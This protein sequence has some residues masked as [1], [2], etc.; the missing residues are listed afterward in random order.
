MITERKENILKGILIEYINSAKPIS[1]K[2]IKKKYNLDFCSA[3]IRNEMQE[4]SE[5]GFL[6][7]PHISA[8]RIP[9]DKAYRFFVDKILEEDRSVRVSRYLDKILQQEKDVFNLTTR[10]SKFLAQRSLSLAAIHLLDDDFFYKEGWGEILEK[11][12]SKED[13]FTSEFVNLIRILEKNIKKVKT[14]RKIKIY[15]GEENPFTKAKN[16]SI[17]I[18]RCSFPDNRQGVISLLGPKRMKYQNN[19]SLIN[20]ILKTLEKK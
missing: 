19:I 18:T 4:L 15:I 14:K 5:M 6:E 9:T 10:L 8:G 20:S 17:I 2:F 11:P 3:T 16:F 13:D 1:S 7:Q 12:E